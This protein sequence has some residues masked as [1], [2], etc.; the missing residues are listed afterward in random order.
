MAIDIESIV[1]R[2]YERTVA[3]NGLLLAGILYAI[4][5]LDAM[6][7]VGLDQQVVPDTGT[8]P[9]GMGPS[10]GAVA[11]PPPISLGL[12]TAVAGFLSLLLGIV[13]L[14]VTI[15]AIRTLV[16]DETETLPREHF[17]QNLAWTALNLIVGGIVFGIVV[18]LGLFAFIVPGLFLL[19]SLFFWQVFVAVEDD[20]FVAGFGNSWSLTSGRRLRVF[21]LG[22][23]G[24]VLALLVGIVFA[25]A[26]V[27]L[28]GVVGF[29][30]EEAGSALV[31]VFILAAV[32]ETYNQ[33]VAA[34]NESEA[35]SNVD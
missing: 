10:P 35:E 17:T 2:G 16:S 21:L 29:L 14:V 8:A 28:P 24:I 20:S 12:P 6:F 7:Y 27:I 30:V 1:R 11:T 18:G 25:I 34:N 22:V 23:V 13:A 19:V 5:L 15:G 33:L 3:R 32:A 4:S 31:G 9:G 26:G